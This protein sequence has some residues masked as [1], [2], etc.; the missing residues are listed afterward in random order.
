MYNLKLARRIKLVLI[1]SG[2]CFAGLWLYFVIR[3]REQ[4]IVIFWFLLAYFFCILEIIKIEKLIKENGEWPTDKSQK[5]NIKVGVLYLYLLVSALSG[6]KAGAYYF[7]AGIGCLRLLQL[8][9]E[10]CEAESVSVYGLARKYF[11]IF[12]IRLGKLI[13]PVEKFKS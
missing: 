11:M 10:R 4:Q 2:L 7:I 6:F 1:I 9:K 3:G 8:L 13:L 12:R 5:V